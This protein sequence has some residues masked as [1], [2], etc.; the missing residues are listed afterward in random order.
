MLGKGDDF[1]QGVLR[2]GRHCAAG[3][4]SGRRRQR[5]HKPGLQT[6]IQFSVLDYAVTNENV[7]RQIKFH[8]QIRRNGAFR[9]YLR[10]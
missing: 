2:H 10:P 5:V 3:I 1:M 8:G 6:E 4:G 9:G 7:I